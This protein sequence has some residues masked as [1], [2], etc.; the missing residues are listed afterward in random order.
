MADPAHEDFSGFLLNDWGASIFI[1]SRLSDQLLS[2][3][4]VD[5]LPAGP[6]AVYTFF[7]PEHA[8]RSLGSFAIMQQIWLAKLYQLPYVYLGYWIENHPK[9]DYKRNFT[10]LEVYQQD[11]WQTLQKI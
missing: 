3:A 6:S 2:V 9:M 8:R 10:G 5:F 7:D 1:E 4:V 11:Q